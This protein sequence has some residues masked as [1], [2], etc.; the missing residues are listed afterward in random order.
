[1]SS[2]RDMPGFNM[3]PVVVA[4]DSPSPFMAM[5]TADGAWSLDML[6]EQAG[7]DRP[8]GV[9]L[10]EEWLSSKDADRE[11]DTGRIV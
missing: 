7:Q 11:D 2:H 6:L 4:T 9:E 5:H 8:R 3:R 10:W 1:M